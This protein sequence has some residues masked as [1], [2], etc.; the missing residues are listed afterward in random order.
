MEDYLNYMNTGIMPQRPD[1]EVFKSMG[2]K[3]IDYYPEDYNIMRLE[4]EWIRKNNDGSQLF[5]MEKI[6]RCDFYSRLLD[7]ILKDAEYSVQKH[8]EGKTFLVNVYGLSTNELSNRLEGQEYKKINPYTYVLR[9]NGYNANINLL[10]KT[11]TVSKYYHSYTTPLRPIIVVYKGIQYITKRHTY[12]IL[13]SKERR[14]YI[15]LGVN[16]KGFNR[17]HRRQ[18]RIPGYSYPTSIEGLN[19][20]CKYELKE[21]TINLPTYWVLITMGYRVLLTKSDKKRL[22]K[23]TYSTMDQ[24][25]GSIKL[26]DLQY[27]KQEC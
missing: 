12:N 17:I 9:V 23:E 16:D 7:P 5:G 25:I 10:S 27:V 26:N 6:S 24:F 4:D 14:Y 22:R 13:C 20:K 11:T 2:H 1:W 8:S 21:G 19:H 15:E 3:D 18:L